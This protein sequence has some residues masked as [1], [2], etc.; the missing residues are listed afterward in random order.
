MLRKLRQWVTGNP[1]APQPSPMAAYPARPALVIPQ[2]VTDAD[3]VARVLQ[4]QGLVVVDF[5]AEW[6]AP[7]TLMSAHVALLAQEFGPQLTVAALDADENPIVPQHYQVMGL[8]T[9]IFFRNGLEIDR[10]VGVTAY[11]ELHRRVADLLAGA[12]GATDGDASTMS[13]P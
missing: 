3:F 10:Q 1:P 12:D 11:E 7:C 8:P 13:L 4:A 6:C 2:D 5:W 9:L